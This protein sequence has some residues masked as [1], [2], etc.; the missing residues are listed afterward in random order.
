MKLGWADEKM[1]E[2]LL[3]GFCCCGCTSIV[4]KGNQ[5]RET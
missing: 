1:V 4:Q 3:V 5:E 2:G